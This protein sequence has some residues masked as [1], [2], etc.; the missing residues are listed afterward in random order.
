M[1]GSLGILAQASGGAERMKKR[2]V[3]PIQEKMPC[4]KCGV[5]FPKPEWYDGWAMVIR[6]QGIFCPTCRE[7]LERNKP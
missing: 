2:K 5:K 1:D 3:K 4:Q 7:K 6:H